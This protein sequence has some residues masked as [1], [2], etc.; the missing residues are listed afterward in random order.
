M[1]L[2]DG[3]EASYIGVWTPTDHPTIAAVPHIVFVIIIITHHNR[4]ATKPQ[5]SPYRDVTP[6]QIASVCLLSLQHL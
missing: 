1:N 2:R 5:G 4:T 6:E 3:F